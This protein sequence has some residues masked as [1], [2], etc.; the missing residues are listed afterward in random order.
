[1]GVMELG[2][3]IALDAPE[4]PAVQEIPNDVKLDKSSTPI[5]TILNAEKPS[6]IMRGGLNRA[7]ESAVRQKTRLDEMMGKDPGIDYDS[8]L[9]YMDQVEM[10]RLDNDKERRMYLESAYGPE[11]VG[12]DTRGRLYVN[13]EGK[14][15][16]SAGGDAFKSLAANVIGNQNSMIG[17]GLG[18]ALGFASPVPGGA[19]I[20]AGLGAAAGE[21]IDQIVKNLRGLQSLTPEQQYKEIASEGVLGTAGEM[22]GRAIAAGANRLMTGRVPKLI[23]GQTPESDALTART[24][25]GGALPPPQST[26]PEASRLKWHYDFANKTGVLPSDI[27]E[28]NLAY[29]NNQFRG[30]LR[31]S[32]VPA[33]KIDEV[34]ESVI[35]PKAAISTQQ[36]GEDIQRAVKARQQALETISMNEMKGV[37]QAIDKY[38]NHLNTLI[39]HYKPGDLGVDVAQ[40]IT[41]ARKMFSRAME[42]PYARV[43]KIVGD[44]PL[45]PSTKIR[46]QAQKIWDSLPKSADG[47]PVIQD[48]RVTTVLKQLQTLGDKIT[49][50]DAQSLR[51][52]LG[53]LGDI[54][55]LVPGVSKRQYGD[56]QN[57]V[58]VAL[59]LAGDDPKAAAAKRL[60]DA[61]DEQYAKGIRKFQDTTINKIVRD[62]ENGLPPDPSVV[63]GL[64][65]KPG[66]TK[67]AETI[68]ELVGPDMWRQIAS[69]DWQN[70]MLKASKQTA[71]R[72]DVVDGR[73][74]RNL[75]NQ[76][77]QMLDTV[78]GPKMASEIRQYADQ[79][80]V[81]DG[82]LP[83]TE[84]NPGNFRSLVESKVRADEA[85]E[86]F[87][88]EDYLSALANPKAIPEDALKIIVQ[89]RNES[90]LEHAFQFFGEQSPQVAQ[91]RKA[92]LLD[93][94]SKAST[95]AEGAAA[96]RID[97]TGLENALKQ[98]TEKQQE[99]LFPNGLADDIRLVAQETKFLFPHKEGDMSAGLASG[100]VKALPLPLYYAT[101]AVPAGVQYILSRP[102]VIRYLA[103]GLR[104]GGEARQATLQLM[105]DGI[106]NLALTTNPDRED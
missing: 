23:G 13:K 12:L 89:P 61:A 84:L 24:L 25:E 93:L 106:R 71:D 76:R 2:G 40:A 10:A 81:R 69:Q 67:Q 29:L 56:L 96:R 48:S 58:D 21:N 35:N 75:L 4:T 49:F 63:A 101:I 78:Y 8:G 28:K 43:D 87:M 100:T 38:E 31:E 27:E 62:A 57:S 90:R 32:G 88:K 7:R 52:A 44:E 66:Y 64:I 20:G 104:G 41:D 97:P 82:T 98:F 6:D 11:N 36:M 72:G 50:R 77:G 102:Q 92:A 34:F 79:L 83:A 85:L 73:K 42:K 59:K 46:E 54:K 22:G 51:T 17:S 99:M 103:L 33:D 65:A 1:M 37:D 14:K 39:T 3:D 70:L 95:T 80:A 74:L 55:D 91:I 94:M 9:S 60:L 5:D 68:R 105:R 30:I 15:V 19:L 18:A 53:D 47:N 26:M 16:S 45:V 86:K